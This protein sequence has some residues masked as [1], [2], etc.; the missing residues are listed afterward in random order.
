MIAVT[1]HQLSS[2]KAHPKDIDK[3]Q[4]FCNYSFLIVT[5]R[6][7]RNKNNDW[8]QEVMAF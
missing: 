6:N 3:N 2:K 5:K 8:H 7:L 1:A 4:T